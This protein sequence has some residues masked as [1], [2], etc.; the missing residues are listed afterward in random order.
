VEVTVNLYGEVR[1]YGKKPAFTLRV[2]AGRS[3]AD[4]L[5]YLKVPEAEPLAI[6]LNGTH[7]GRNQPLAE[8]DVLSIFS[9]AAFGADAAAE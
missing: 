9:M 1:K 2:P 7:V 4:V 3:V 8:D 6:V 5:A